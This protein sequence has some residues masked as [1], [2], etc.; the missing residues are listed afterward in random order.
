MPG[1]HCGRDPSDAD[2]TGD[3]GDN[4]AI[5]EAFSMSHR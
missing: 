5:I 2:T 1:L 4:K 3:S